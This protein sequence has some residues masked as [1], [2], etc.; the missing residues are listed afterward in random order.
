MTTR[1]KSPCIHVCALNEN[2]LCV[3]CY[4]SGDEI[5]GWMEMSNDERSEVLRLVDKRILKGE[6][7]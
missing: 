1:V 5:L 3:G 7:L 4:R 6:V 2:D